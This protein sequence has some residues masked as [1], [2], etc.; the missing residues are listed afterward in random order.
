[1]ITDLKSGRDAF[2]PCVHVDEAM[3]YMIRLAELRDWTKDMTEMER[4]DLE[5][6]VHVLMRDYMRS[7]NST[8]N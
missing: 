7:Q 3:L 4:K 1:M 2:M 5:P 6:K 8:Q